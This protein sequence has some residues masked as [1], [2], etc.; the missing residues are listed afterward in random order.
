MARSRK[1]PPPEPRG[2]LDGQFIVAMPGMPDERFA[3][4]VIYICAHSSDGAMGLIINRP[5]E[6]LALPELLV[7]L[8]LL[9]NAAAIRLPVTAENVPVL[10]GGP[11]ERGRGFVLH[12]NDFFLENSSLPIDDGLA[13]TITVDILTA[14][15]NGAGPEK[16][17]V[18]LGYAGWSP[19]QLEQEMQ[20]NSWLNCPADPTLIFDADHHTKYERAIR[21]MG[22]DPRMLSSDAGH[23]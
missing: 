13:M 3:R 14:I 7:Q 10:E 5:T 1:S 8:K 22:I 20:N 18:A 15:A 4:T 2:F 17:V 9:D 6:S 11:V 12:T 19:G 23:A 16:A 21:S